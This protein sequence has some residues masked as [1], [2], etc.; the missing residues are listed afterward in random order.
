M[1]SNCKYYCLDNKIIYWMYIQNN[2]WIVIAMYT[3]IYTRVSTGTQAAEGTSLDTQYD[4]CLKKAMQL[5][6]PIEEI[7]LYREE[8]V[9]GEELDRPSLDKLRDDVRDNKVCRLIITHPDRL[10]RDLYSKVTICRELE[11]RDVELIFNDVEY[12]NT[13]EGQLFFN[14]MSSIAQYELSQIRSRTVRGRKRAVE[15]LGKIMPMRVPPYGYDL[16]DQKLVI[17]QVEA[18]FVKMIYKWYVHESKSLKQ[19]GELLYSLGAIPKRAES[20]N[21]SA[22]SIG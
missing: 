16:V 13:P 19:I 3:A 2:D 5:N 20:K 9:T 6:I 7:V 1:R 21:W 12:K 17:N 10:S 22:S 11:T 18:N 8:G 14:L 15:D 4:I